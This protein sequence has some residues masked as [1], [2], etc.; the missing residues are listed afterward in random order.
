MCGV[1]GRSGPWPTV[2]VAGSLSRLEAIH[3]E[4]AAASARAAWSP[5][6]RPLFSIARITFSLNPS[7]CSVR[8]C[9]GS[10]ANT[11]RSRSISARMTVS[12]TPD[13][14]RETIWSTVMANA[15]RGASTAV[16]TAPKT[17]A[18]RTRARMRRIVQR[19]RQR[20]G[21]EI[22]R[23]S[24]VPHGR[25][26]TRSRTPFIRKGQSAAADD[27]VSFGFA[28]TYGSAPVPGPGT[29]L[30]SRSVGSKEFGN[31]FE[32]T[33]VCGV[34]DRVHRRGSRRRLSRHTSEHRADAGVG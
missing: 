29:P 17:R 22:L 3:A 5:S 26:W 27:L 6:A 34:G 30:A 31:A 2:T 20:G 13:L 15:G 33:R 25:D 7:R 19:I 18:Y 10:I 23:N 8:I 32:S 24:L 12:V 28:R 21:G 1:F 11:V 4:L 14:A 9:S 16:T